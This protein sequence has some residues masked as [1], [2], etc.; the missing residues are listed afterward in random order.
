MLVANKI[1]LNNIRAFD[2]VDAH[3]LAKDLGFIG[4]YEVSAD[5]NINVSKP[6]E[7]LI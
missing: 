2:P 6:I 7:D 5:A 3:K 1:D 4:Y